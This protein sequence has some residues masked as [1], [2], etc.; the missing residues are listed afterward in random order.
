V[1]GARWDE[2]SLQ[3]KTWTVPAGRM[4]GGK[5][6]RVP[7]SERAIELLHALPR[8]DGNDFVFIG[9]R[10][11]SGLGPQ[12][13]VQ[14]LK[15]KH[16][17]FTVHGMRSCFKDWCSETTN[18]P[19]FVVEMAMAHAIPNVVEAA[20]RRGDLLRKRQQLAEAWSKYCT[21]PPPAGAIVVPMRKGAQA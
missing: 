10:A 20:Y 1:I 6:H 16:P 15:S 8:E 3:D 12:S 21:S 9:A 14:V 2:I 11:G 19:N 18:F 13:L 7:L 17:D 4:K 5:E